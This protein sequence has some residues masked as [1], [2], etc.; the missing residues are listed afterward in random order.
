[1]GRTIAINILQT[2]WEGPYPIVE[3]VYEN[4]YKLKIKGKLKVYHANRL[5]NFIE[6]ED[7]STTDYIAHSSIMKQT[8][9]IMKKSS[10]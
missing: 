2:Q 7:E 4:N 8:I 9:D 5:K 10:K 6:R 3:K 1:M